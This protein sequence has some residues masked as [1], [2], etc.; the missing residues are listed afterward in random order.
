MNSQLE[1]DPKLLADV[2][3]FQK[4]EMTGARLYGSLSRRIKAK[5]N[6]RILS[7]MAQ[8]ELGH[9]AFWKSL[10]GRDAGPYRLRLFFLYLAA[11]LFGLTFALKLLERAEGRAQEGYARVAHLVP[12]AE[13]IGKEEE[14]H[15]D[16]LI[17]MIE[18]ERLAYVGSIVLGLNDALVELTGALAGLT[19]ALQKG[20]IVAV[21][22]IITGI[23]AA[24]SMAASDYLSSKA[25]NDPRAKKSAIYTG[26][27]YLLTVILLVVPYL[28]L[29]QGGA[30]I[31]ASLAM[32]LCIAVLI[33]AG[34]NFYVAVAKDQDF[35]SRF[36]EMAGISLGVAAFSFAVGF[37]VRSVFG[38][39]L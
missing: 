35:K 11:R 2:L 23:A 16:A 36:L 15:E 8:A 5:E 39:D 4:E 32:T 22:G 7:D 18:E 37:L 21:S 1:A 31:Y 14:A 10:S 33:I 9:Y 27:A 3:R 34:F 28:I 30:W 29:P 25:D 12:E 20:S 19:F 17:G 38:V 6:A 13:R 26:V 24:F